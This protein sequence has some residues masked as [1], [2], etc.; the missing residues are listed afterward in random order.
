MA[1]S[2]VN[3]SAAVTLVGAF[4]TAGY[5]GS[6]FLF[7]KPKETPTKR[8]SFSVSE[9][10]SKDKT[11]TLLKTSLGKDHA[12]W[13]TA[14]KAYVEKNAS[15][16]AEGSDPLKISGWATK[17][18]TPDSVPEEFLNRCDEESK[19]TVSSV[20]DAVYLTVSTWCTK[21]SST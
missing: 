16:S 4:G 21:V 9:L 8:K 15:N 7:S 13:K 3:Y 14:W 6:K 18:S 2:L 5:F 19:K 10:L 20:S 12:D 11:K 1:S 17:K